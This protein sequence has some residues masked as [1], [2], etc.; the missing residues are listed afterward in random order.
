MRWD[1]STGSGA[2]NRIA[3]DEPRYAGALHPASALSSTIPIR[4]SDELWRNEIQAFINS[5]LGVELGWRHDGEWTLRK[6]PL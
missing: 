2:P 6:A 4:H 1:E 5:L 3:V